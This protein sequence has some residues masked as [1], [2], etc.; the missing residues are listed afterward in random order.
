MIAYVRW[1]ES[2]DC[3]PLSPGQ[4]LDTARRPVP[5]TSTPMASYRP[6][7]WL[8]ERPNKIPKCYSS[9]SWLVIDVYGFDS[10]GKSVWSL[11]VDSCSDIRCM[12]EIGW[13]FRA[14]NRLLN[15]QR[16]STT[17]SYSLEFSFK[18]GETEFII[19]SNCHIVCKCTCKL[20]VF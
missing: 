8:S 10:T 7:L 5:G 1:M 12:N 14:L 16:L 4:A 20:S 19:S 9:T 2:L 6:P 3:R 18:L 11:L 15:G 13:I 17:I